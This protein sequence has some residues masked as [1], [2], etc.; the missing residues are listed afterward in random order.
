M[1]LWESGQIPFW[2]NGGVPQASKCFAQSNPRRNLSRQVPIQLK[3]LTSAFFILGVGLSLAIF[4]F[5]VEKISYY[6]KGRQTPA[7]V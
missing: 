2:V 4:S 5:L 1:L 7:I 6:F 3:D